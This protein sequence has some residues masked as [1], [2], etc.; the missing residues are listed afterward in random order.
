MLVFRNR[1]L[2][3]NC[4]CSLFWNSFVQ[5]FCYT[6]W[7]FK[8]TFFIWPHAIQDGKKYCIRNVWFF[9]HWLPNEKNHGFPTNNWAE[10]TIFVTKKTKTETN[11][12]IQKFK[13][14]ILTPKQLKRRWLGNLFF[15]RYG[16]K[17]YIDLMADVITA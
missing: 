17:W 5:Y 2:K 12:K 1:E 11:L 3:K 13:A 6:L 8:L 7:F 16:T 10:T 4:T 9:C 14:L 15:L